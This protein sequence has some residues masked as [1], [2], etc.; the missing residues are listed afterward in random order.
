LLKIIQAEVKKIPEHRLGFIEYSMRNV[1][2]S[3]LA[4]FALKYPSLL[5]F[6]KNKNK[7][8]IKYNLRTTQCF[9]GLKVH[10]PARCDWRG[11]AEYQDDKKPRI[12]LHHHSDGKRPSVAL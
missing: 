7:Q 6:D 2:M 10:C 8:H 9:A 12:F 1:M 4:V 11:C 5:E 3:G